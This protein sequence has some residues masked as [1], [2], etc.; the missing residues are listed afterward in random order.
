M[1]E[2]FYS[3][4]NI[5]VPNWND[6]LLMPTMICLL[7]STFLIFLRTIKFFAFSM[8]NKMKIQKL[9]NIESTSLLNNK[10]KSDD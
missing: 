10:Q 9:S 6:S 3:H 8:S 4:N 7:I 5:Q 2:S 1:A